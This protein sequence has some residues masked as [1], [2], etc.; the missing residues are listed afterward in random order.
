MPASLDNIC[1]ILNVISASHGQVVRAI[2]NKIF[3]DF[4][5]CLQ[6]ECAKTV[7]A[8]FIVTCNVRDYTCAGTTAV[9]PDQFLDILNGVI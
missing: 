4:E 8:Q 3:K 5:D 9:T 7:N 2:R 1:G 6:D